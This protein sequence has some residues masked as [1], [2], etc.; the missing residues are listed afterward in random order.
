VETE[1]HAAG[2]AAAPQDPLRQLE[3]VR[4]IGGVSFINDS[5][6]T[7]VDSVYWALKTVS[8][9]AILIAGGKD[10]AGDFTVLNKLIKKKIK[11]VVLI[12][13]ASEKIENTWKDIV[14]CIKTSDMSEAVQKSFEIANDGD[15]VLLSPG[16]AS[17]DMYTS[18]EHRG[19]EFKR[20]V[21]SLTLPKV[22]Q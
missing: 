14:T 8:A 11:T 7:N 17:F 22:A 6:G 9:P 2:L 20:I 21:N 10:K 13:E 15:T 5:K 3:P 18:F 19:E 12:G 4:L 16:C 1:L